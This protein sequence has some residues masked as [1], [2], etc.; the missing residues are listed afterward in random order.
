[1]LRRVLGAFGVRRWLRTAFAD[2]GR[3]RVHFAAW[4]WSPAVLLHTGQGAGRPVRGALGHGGRQHQRHRHRGYRPRRPLV[5]HQSRR[6][7]VTREGAGKP[8]QQVVDETV[9]RDRRQ[10]SRLH[11][12]RAHGVRRVHAQRQRRRLPHQRQRA[13][14]WELPVDGDQGCRVR[15][16]DASVR[17]VGGRIYVAYS[18]PCSCIPGNDRPCISRPAPTR[19]PWTKSLITTAAMSRSCEWRRTATSRRYTR[20]EV[21]AMPAST[22]TRIVLQFEDPEHERLRRRSRS[23]RSTRTAARESSIEL[24][25]GYHVSY[26]RQTAG[27]F[28]TPQTVAPLTSRLRVRPGYGRHAEGRPG[29]EHRGP[30]VHAQRHHVAQVED[31]LGDRRRG[32]RSAA[33]VQRQSRRCRS[34][35]TKGGIWVTRG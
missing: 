33:R 30:A 17:V 27:G 15:T 5:R 11:R 28:G 3:R 23:S 12:P 31:Q 6:Q 1:M 2:D 21:S 26:E 24:K 18:S 25:N 13:A 19:P 14:P 22:N 29:R 8:D 34:D 10:R 9:D 4:S 20:H 7:L 16:G 32:R 35:D